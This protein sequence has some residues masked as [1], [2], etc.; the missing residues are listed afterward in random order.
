MSTR[1]TEA[2]VAA[3]AAD[4]R[5]VRPL[6][7]PLERALATLGLLALG[8]GLAILLFA[9][10][11]GLLARYAGR[12]AMMAMEMAAMLA[13]GLIAVTGAFFLAI[14]GRSRR[15]LWAPLPPLAAWI[16][17][18]GMG[19]W[20]DLLR[21]GTS[22][23]ALGESADCLIFILAASLVLGAP[24]VWRLSRAQPIEPLR[25]ALLAGLG[26]AALAAFLLQFFHPFAITFLD[27]G[28]HFA[29]MLAVIAAIAAAN[30]RAL[31]A[32]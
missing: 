19:C 8:G 21:H 20:R 4:A 14:P 28:V 12:E 23:W 6:A 1:R 2:L 30:R 17:L 5:P 18:S 24:I 10:V 27:L 7:P 15:W 25:V 3:I 16:A 22:G 11:P 26:I 32:A 31:A 13:T 9:D 29:A